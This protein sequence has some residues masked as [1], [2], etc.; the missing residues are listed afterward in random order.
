[1]G[2]KIV[3][4]KVL[5]LLRNRTVTDYIICQDKFT[6]VYTNDA[7]KLSFQ[8]RFA[9]VRV[10]KYIDKT[11]TKLYIGDGKNLEFGKYDL[12]GDDENKGYKTFSAKM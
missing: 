6:D 10:E 4:V 7:L 8:G 12:K 11:R 5:S 1:M 3:G 9:I 2:D